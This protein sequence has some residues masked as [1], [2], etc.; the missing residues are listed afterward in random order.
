MRKF[1][2]KP[3]TPRGKYLKINSV[4]VEWD[5]KRRSFAATIMFHKSRYRADTKVLGTILFADNQETMEKMIRE[6][7]LLYPVRNEMIVC[8]PDLE[9][10]GE[11]WSY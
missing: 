4:K 6:L 11:F 8:I 10:K 2:L 7:N 5:S 9:Q 3:C 1:I